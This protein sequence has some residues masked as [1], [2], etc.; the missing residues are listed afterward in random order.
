M[1]VCLEVLPACMHQFK[2][3]CGSRGTYTDT[4]APSCL[5]HTVHVP[6]VPHACTAAVVAMVYYSRA[7]VLPKVQLQP[8]EDMPTS[9]LLQASFL[10]QGKS[11]KFPLSLRH[12]VLY[13]R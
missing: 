5:Y 3:V 6:H 2:G 7:A 8:A 1:L 12:C 4:S 10:G 11:C 13:C 9:S